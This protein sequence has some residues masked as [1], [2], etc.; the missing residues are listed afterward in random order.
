MSSIMAATGAGSLYEAIKKITDHTK[1]ASMD[2]YRYGLITG[3]NA[4]QMQSWAHAAEQAGVQGDVV[5][6]T[7][8]DLQAVQQK[9]KLWGLDQNVATGLAMI[10]NIGKVRIT[11]KDYFGDIATY[12]EKVKKGIEGVD[13]AQQRQILGLLGINEQMLL[14]YK[15]Q[16]FSK[17]NNQDVFSPETVAKMREMNAEWVRLGVQLEY[18]GSVFATEISPVIIGTTRTLVNLI[19]ELNDSWPG[20]L[21]RMS[22]EGWGRIGEYT[23]YGLDSFTDSL[24]KMLAGQSQLAPQYQPGSNGVPNINATFHFSHVVTPEEMQKHAMYA[25]N[26]AV[27]EAHNKLPPKGY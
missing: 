11:M 27:R 14:F 18:V 7:F 16:E 15:S 5:K 17:R 19:K 8:E 20:K 10:Q 2:L 3:M 23:Q 26:E 12:Q 4:Q 1:D 21:A 25:L 22:G 24:A 13:A 9:A 6:K